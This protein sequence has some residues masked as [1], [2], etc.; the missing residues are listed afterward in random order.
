MKKK[1][2]QLSTIKVK[3]FTAILP[4]EQQRTAKGGAAAIIDKIRNGKGTWTEVKSG[5]ESVSSIVLDTRL[6]R[7]DHLLRS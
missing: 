2:L 7:G 6:E 5:K 4:T 3:S 1:K